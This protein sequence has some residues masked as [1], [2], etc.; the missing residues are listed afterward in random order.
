MELLQY[1]SF[2]LVGIKGVAMTSLA[3]LLLDA[4]KK[5][6]GSDVT[7]DFPTKIQLDRLQLSADTSFSTPL[8]SDVDCVIYTGAH[9]GQHNPQVEWARANNI[10]TLTHAQALAYFF[11]QKQGIAVCGVGGKSTISAM[12]TWVLT[13]LQLD[14]S[15]SVGVGNIPG[16]NATGAWTNSPYFVAEADEYVEDPSVNGAEIVPRFA[17]LHPSITVCPNLRFDHPDVYRDFDHT[18]E[19]FKTFFGQTKDTLIVNADDTELLELAKQSHSKILTFG[20]SE[21]ADFR[22]TS[23][24]VENGKSH[25]IFEYQ[26]SA[27][28]FTLT[29]PGK[30]NALNA[31]AAI[32]T[33]T[34]VDPRTLDQHSLE[35][36]RSTSRRFENIG[37]INGV[38][39]YD[40]YAHH[41]HEIKAAI[42]ALNE[43]CPTQRKVIAFQSH[44]FSRTKQLFDEF[45]DAFADAQEV[46]MTDI[47]ASAR[48]AS[49]PTISSTILCEAIEQKY[50]IKATNVSTN[51]KLAEY[52]KTNLQAGDVFLT[53]GAGDIYEV[54]DVIRQ[55]ERK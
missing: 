21:T 48:E 39:C 5:A 38:Q 2:Y 14:P 19:V 9:Q 15:F 23:Y 10:P 26:G 16:L 17:Y 41:P 40:D 25:S 35:T 55:D 13:S 1:T 4:G 30:F 45:V 29:I 53:L 22:L 27:Y 37:T 12:I 47:F 50:G 51:E 11:N 8:P 6:Q 18:R 43:W 46:V 33:A 24:T 7:E 32:A 36:F 31:L 52:F 28:A 44:T 20:E 49:D 54:Y 42:A 34:Q 3:Q